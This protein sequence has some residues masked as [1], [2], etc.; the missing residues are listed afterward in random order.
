[1][2]YSSILI[3]AYIS[4]YILKKI[5]CIGIYLTDKVSVKILGNSTEVFGKDLKSW[6]N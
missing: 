2:N 1:M 3:K 5:K 6:M 4:I